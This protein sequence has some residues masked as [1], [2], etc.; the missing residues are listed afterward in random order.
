MTKMMVENLSSRT[1]KE[2]L[3]KLFSE[4]GDVCSQIR[5][6]DLTNSCF[7]N[8]TNDVCQSGFS[9]TTGADH[10]HD[11]PFE[12]LKR[13]STKSNDFQICCLVNLVNIVYT[14][15]NVIR[16][17]VIQIQLLST[18]RNHTIFAVKDIR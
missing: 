9:R 13:N 14:Y 16:E 7:S 3:N 11:F 12:D 5:P 6:I 17:V 2:S 15:D 18:G 4:F 1:T 10:T 8:A